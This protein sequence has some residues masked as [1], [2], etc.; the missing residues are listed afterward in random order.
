[1]GMNKELT[2]YEV[3][4]WMVERDACEFAI[5]WFMEQNDSLQEIYNNCNDEIYIRWLYRKI[6][7]DRQS[8]EIQKLAWKQYIEIQEPAWE[9]YIEI[10]EPAWEQYLKTIEPT[11]KQ[12]I[13]AIKLDWVVVESAL[14]KAIRGNGND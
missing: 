11:W 12:Y 10:Q 5:D 6:G 14:I 1:M 8:P 2:Y 3:L 4:Q 7:L 13:E 9:Q